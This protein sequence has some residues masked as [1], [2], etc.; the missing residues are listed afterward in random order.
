MTEGWL[1]GAPSQYLWTIS[2]RATDYQKNSPIFLFTGKRGN[3]TKNRDE[4]TLLFKVGDS[5]IK[6]LAD[7]R[8][9]KTTE[10]IAT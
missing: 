4:K 3:H 10:E 8:I 7:L 2:K 6:G 9:L 5:D 1:K